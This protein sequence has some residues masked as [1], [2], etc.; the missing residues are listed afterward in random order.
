MTATL[1]KPNI[2]IRSLHQYLDMVR[3]V[4]SFFIRDQVGDFLATTYS[5]HSAIVGSFLR[6]A[7]Y[8]SKPF[9]SNTFA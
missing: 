4:D 1:V 9:G 2:V 3:I 5:A 8:F 6:P 7:S